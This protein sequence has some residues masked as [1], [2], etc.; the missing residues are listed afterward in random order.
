MDPKWPQNMIFWK[1]LSLDFRGNN[2][3][4][5]WYCYWYVTTNPISRKILILELW[6]K[7]LLANEIARFFR[8]QC[9][10]KEVN[11]EVF[12]GMQINIEVFY[13]F[14][15]SFWVSIAGHA[16]STQSKKFAYL[17]NKLI[18]C[19]LINTEVFYKFIGLLWVCIAGHAQN[20]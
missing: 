16:Q 19:L 18:F 11:D 13:K 17:C 20:T 6:A 1:I 5:K 12:F 14:I 9:L 7:M 15:L 10:T 3:I 2:Q 8:M 4:E